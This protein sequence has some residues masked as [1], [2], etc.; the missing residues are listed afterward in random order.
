MKTLAGKH[1]EE[2]G[3]FLSVWQILA[4]ILIVNG[5]SYLPGALWANFLSI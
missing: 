1:K 5:D 4:R 2:K 3:Y